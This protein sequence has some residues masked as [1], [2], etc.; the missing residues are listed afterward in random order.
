M[1]CQVY[2]HVYTDFGL[3]GSLMVIT[4]RNFPTGRPSGESPRRRRPCR[5]RG[6]DTA[7]GLGGPSLCGASQAGL[8]L[9]LGFRWQSSTPWALALFDSGVSCVASGDLDGIV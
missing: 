9:R 1:I 4:A 7:Y 2:T 5:R 3:Q 8:R 6:V